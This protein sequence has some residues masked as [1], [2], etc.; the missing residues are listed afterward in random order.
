MFCWV[1]GVHA[2]YP[3]LSMNN[4]LYDNNVSNSDNNTVTWVL[5]LHQAENNW[6]SKVMWLRIILLIISWRLSSDMLINAWTLLPKLLCVCGN[7][8]DPALALAKTCGCR[9]GDQGGLF[10]SLKCL[11]GQ[12]YLETQKPSQG[13]LNMGVITVWWVGR[14]PIVQHLEWSHTTLFPVPPALRPG[15]APCPA[16]FLPPFLPLSPPLMNA[17]TSPASLLIPKISSPPRPIYYRNK[18]NKQQ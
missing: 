18:T 2:R 16:P 14:Q 3:L 15:R 6:D 7:Y 4:L 8:W 13:V 10:C 1:L 5:C 11:L 9:A 17:I 12:A